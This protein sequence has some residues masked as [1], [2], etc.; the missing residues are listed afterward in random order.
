M[1]NLAIINLAARRAVL[2]GLLL[3]SIAACSTIP[4]PEIGDVDSL[5]TERRQNL[6]AQNGWNIQGRI[7][8]YVDDQVHTAGL[9][10]DRKK[11]I[12][13]IIIEAPFGQGALLIESSVDENLGLIYQL[14]L[15]DNKTFYGK[16]PES[17]L[18]QVFGWE[19]P[20]TGL[21]QWV[22]A[23]PLDSEPFEVI[24]D[25]FG[26]PKS[27]IQR[28]WRINYLDYP[29]TSNPTRDLPERMYLKHERLAIKLS[30]EQWQSTVLEPTD[31]K[32][33]FPSFD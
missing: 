24:F 15:P 19:I 16:T 13:K 12:L 7:A 11:D 9:R 33:E 4:K 14:T 8:L 32:I 1:L 10:W 31:S 5:W 21:N 28:D 29:S 25:D 6:A 30:I 26:Y 23:V 17:L 3:L 20:V 27:I 22:K 2:T 18:N